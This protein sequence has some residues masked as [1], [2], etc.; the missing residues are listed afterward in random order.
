MRG[1][2]RPLPCRGR[3]LHAEGHLVRAFLCPALSVESEEIPSLGHYVGSV[4]AGGAETEPGASRGHR[5][6]D[7]AWM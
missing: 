4:G 7:P 3:H 1:D 2:P 6:A 5:L